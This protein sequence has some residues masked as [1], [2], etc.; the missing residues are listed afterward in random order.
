LKK[1][2]VGCETSDGR[3]VPSS[4]SGMRYCE[5]LFPPAV[6]SLEVRWAVEDEPERFWGGAFDALP[7]DFVEFAEAELTAEDSSAA[8]LSLVD[9]LVE[10]T[11]PSVLA[12]TYEVTSC[13]RWKKC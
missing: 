9:A 12:M 3:L 6:S 13:R 7:P 8:R 10:S 5:V 4:G 1:Y 2:A 11:T